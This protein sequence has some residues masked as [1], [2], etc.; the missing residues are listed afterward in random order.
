MKITQNLLT[1]ACLLSA[2]VANAALVPALSG[3]V[4]NDT[5]LNIA[6]LSN[7]NLAASNTFGLQTGIDLGPN[8][9]VTNYG[10]S[11]INSN[12]TMTWGGALK[13][14]SAMNAANYLG[15]NNWRL[16]TVIDTG[17]PG[18][19]YAYSGTDCGFNINTATS[20]MAHLYY[21]ELGNLASVDTAGGWPQPGWGL[22][23][24][25]PFTN[26]QSN[27]YWSGTE[28][29]PITNYAWLFGFGDGAQGA[30][31]K[32]SNFYALA[33]RPGQVAAMPVPAAVWLFGSGLLGLIGMARRKPA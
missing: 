27:L 19:D 2:T 9:G 6:W 10:P 25:G 3:Q 23:N 17:T 20:E 5:D 8:P 30:G 13:W 4:V 24:T 29:A 14:I 7:A 21:D 18:C 22:V 33:V 12:G 26:L 15:Y 11:I 31:Y 32:S 16:P 28:D 1:A